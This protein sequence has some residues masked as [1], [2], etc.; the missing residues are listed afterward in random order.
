[1]G[2]AA[3]GADRE[4]RCRRNTKR[5]AQVLGVIRDVGNLVATGV[6][7]RRMNSGG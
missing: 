2:E 4:C 5:L 6:G 7:G 3:V 1:M